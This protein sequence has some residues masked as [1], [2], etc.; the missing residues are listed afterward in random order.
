VATLNY[1]SL[2]LRRE[3]RGRKCCTAT[4]VGYTKKYK[5]HQVFTEMQAK[6]H[7]VLAK[8]SSV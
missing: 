2:L 8:D 7:R 6:L 5:K 4:A 3:P 1:S